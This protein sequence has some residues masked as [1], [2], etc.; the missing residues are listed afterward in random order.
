MAVREVSRMRRTPPQEVVAGPSAE[1]DCEA[2][3]P[4]GPADE[5]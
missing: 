5:E 3:R 2:Q 1:Q 4:N